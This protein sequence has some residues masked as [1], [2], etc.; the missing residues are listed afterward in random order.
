MCEREKAFYSK[1]I[2]KLLTEIESYIQ[3]LPCLTF[4]GSSYDI[5]LV[6][7]NLLT[8]LGLTAK[9]NQGY[10]IKK[11]SKFMC[12]STPE[13]RFLDISQYLSPGVSY[14]KFLKAYGT[15]LTNIFFSI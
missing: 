12:I 5:N 14:D 3:Q 6:K 11:N 8:R 13:L 7:K 9:D 2:K 4:N 10:V 15:E 1:F